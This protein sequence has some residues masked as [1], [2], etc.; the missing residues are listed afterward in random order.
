M[1][2]AIS[3]FEALLPRGKTLV[4]PMP[5]HTVVS[6][7]PF[8]APSA[9]LTDPVDVPGE[10]EVKDK[11]KLKSKKKPHKSRKNG[12]DQESKHKKRHRSPSP[13][14][15]LSTDKKD[16][17]KNPVSSSVT[18]AQDNS[19]HR[20]LLSQGPLYKAAPVRS[21]AHRLSSNHLQAKIALLQHIALSLSVKTFHPS[22]LQVQKLSVSLQRHSVHLILRLLPVHRNQMIFLCLNR[23]PPPPPPPPTPTPHPP[24]PLFGYPPSTG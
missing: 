19:N 23:I 16:S 12:S 24:T 20:S 21:L 18:G 7:S 22:T 9:W 8:I 3:C 5:P 17:V 13:V 4:K 15:P 11:S 6:D 14:K 1:G 2:G 10:V